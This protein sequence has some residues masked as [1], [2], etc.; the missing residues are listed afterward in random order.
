MEPNKI[1][2]EEYRERKGQLK[3]AMRFGFYFEAIFIEYAIIEDRTES[4]LRHAGDIK[5][6]NSRE[7]PL[8]LTEKLNKIKSCSQFHDKNI[9]RLLSLELLSS[10]DE[11]RKKRNEI[12]HNLMNRSDD[13]DELKALAEQ[14][15]ELV[16][17]LDN[18]VSAVN[19]RFDNTNSHIN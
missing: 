9:R 19:R 14:G 7:Q 8:K 10:I 18:K 11:W 3:K 5:L 6:T 17:V 2:Q 1:K 13:L 4:V 15:Q 12:V 16:R